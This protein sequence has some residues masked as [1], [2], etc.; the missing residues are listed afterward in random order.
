MNSEE[1]VT[2]RASLLTFQGEVYALDDKWVLSGLGHKYG[3]DIEA[4]KNARV[5]HFNGKMKPWLEL[6][7]HDYTVFWRKFVDPENQFLSD[8]NIN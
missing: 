5:L 4:V 1:A 2:L 6:G 7:I 8:C 3:V